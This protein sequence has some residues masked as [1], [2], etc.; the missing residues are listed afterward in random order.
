VVKLTMP[1]IDYESLTK[2]IGLV[3]TVNSFP[4]FHIDEA[5]T[6]LMKFCIERL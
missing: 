2:Y 3:Q 5:I 1:I 6:P 4:H